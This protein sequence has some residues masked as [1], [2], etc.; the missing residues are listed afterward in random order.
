MYPDVFSRTSITQAYIEMHETSLK[1]LKEIIAGS[2]PG[3]EVF[4]KMILKQT[5][6]LNFSG[7]NSVE[8][9]YQRD[10]EEL[11]IKLSSYTTRDV[12]LISTKEFYA[13]LSYAKKENKPGMGRSN[14]NNSNR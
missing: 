13:L 4:E 1:I 12:K 5:E 9:K 10:Y 2:A 8:I 14:R 7:K 11:C 3:E 6:P